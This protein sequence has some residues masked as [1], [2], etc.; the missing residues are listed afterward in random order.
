MALYLDGND[1]ALFSSPDLKS[2]TK[3]CDVPMLGSGECPDFFALPVDGDAKNVKWVFWA[4]NNNYMLGSFD[5]KVFRKETGPLPSHFGANRY[6]AQTFS[7]IPPA[8]GRR[9]Q[10][11]WMSGGKYPGMPFNQQMSIPVE[12]R[13]G[14]SPK[15]CGSARCLLARSSGFARA[16]PSRIAAS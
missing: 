6:A 14:R 10:I 8:D 1:Y 15:A 11:A 16:S 9:I 7:D 3:L 2:W 12:L 4:A 5:G 13:C